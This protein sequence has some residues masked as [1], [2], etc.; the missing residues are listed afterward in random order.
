MRES[1]KLS[2]N[3]EQLFA[4]EGMS[5]VKIADDISWKY[6]KSEYGL[7]PAQVRSIA[8]KLH[9]EAEKHRRQRKSKTF[10]GDVEALLAD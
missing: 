7:S 5:S 2:R 9:A 4:E 6:A 10:H 1:A 3:E 8:R